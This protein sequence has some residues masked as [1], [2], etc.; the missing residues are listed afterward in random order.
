[1]VVELGATMHH[2]GASL[3]TRKMSVFGIDIA[4]LVLHVVGMDDTGAVVLRKRLARSEFLHGIATLPSPLIGMAACGSTPYW[5]RCFQAHGHAPDC[6]AICQ[7][8]GAVA[9]A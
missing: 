3:M 4:P 7:S 6:A 2:K 5:A 1:M 9:E 8:L